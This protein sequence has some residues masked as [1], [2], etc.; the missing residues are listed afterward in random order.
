MSELRNCDT[1][2]ENWVKW[3]K[4]TIST[5]SRKRLAFHSQV[6]PELAVGSCISRK[7]ARDT[8]EAAEFVSLY[9]HE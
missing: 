9:V 7:L 2:C 1:R 3:T 4:V 6:G 8:G 5:L